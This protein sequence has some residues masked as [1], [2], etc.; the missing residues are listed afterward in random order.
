[1]P[2][3]EHREHRITRHVDDA[4]P[5]GLDLVTEDNARRV[6]SRDGRVLIGRHETGV[7]GRIGRQNPHQALPDIRVG[8][9]WHSGGISAGY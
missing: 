9:R 2:S 8:H 4:P 3:V 6:E 7:P 1:M 5:P